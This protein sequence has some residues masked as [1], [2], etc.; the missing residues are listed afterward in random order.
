MIKKWFFLLKTAFF[1][2]EIKNFSVRSRSRPLLPGVEAAF[3]AR[4]WS[5]LQDLGRLE[6]EPPKKVA[7]L[8]HWEG[9]DD[10]DDDDEGEN[11]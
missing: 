3:F 9:D 1:R 4:S 11:Q 6:L 5:R 10:D 8:Q 7:A 2:A